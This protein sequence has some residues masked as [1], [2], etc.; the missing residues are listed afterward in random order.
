MNGDREAIV[1][2]VVVDVWLL[3]L[4]FLRDG[5][6][7]VGLA[8]EN[9]PMSESESELDDTAVL[10]LEGT[11]PEIGDDD[12]RDVARASIDDGLDQSGIETDVECIPP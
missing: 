7:R 9:M 4:M 3:L 11:G 8:W 10:L 2:P 6:W 1:R 5:Y 12:S